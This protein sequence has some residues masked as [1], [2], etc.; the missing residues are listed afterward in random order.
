[1]AAVG[2][3]SLIPADEPAGQVLANVGGG[4]LTGLQGFEQAHLGS[5]IW[6]HVTV[7]LL[8]RPIWLVPLAAGVVCVGAVVSLTWLRA[9]PRRRRRS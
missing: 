1:M 4:F 9:P 5:W 6:Q 3:G 2:L 7:P 8:V